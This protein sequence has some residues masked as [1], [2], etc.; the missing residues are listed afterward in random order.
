M[1]I[2]KYQCDII[3]G[4]L[5]Y[6]K[7][8]K[9]SVVGDLWNR[10]ENLESPNDVIFKHFIVAAVSF[11]EDV[12]GMGKKRNPFFKVDCKK[13]NP[14][15]F[16]QLFTVVLCYFS[17]LFSDTNKWLKVDIKQALIEITKNPETVQRIVREFEKYHTK[18][19]GLNLVRIS[20]KTEDEI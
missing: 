2:F 5:K 3:S 18:R 8:I 11:I 6:W 13:I 14:Q 19:D 1:G 20:G 7:E 17:F 15:K 12:V 9:F 4:R 10:L 16:C